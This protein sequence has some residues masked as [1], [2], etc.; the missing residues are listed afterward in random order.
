MTLLRP[1]LRV[2]V[3]L[4][5][6]A[7]SAAWPALRAV[8]GI[9]P[10]RRPVFGHGVEVEPGGGA[11]TV[12]GCYHVSQQNTFTGRLT[13]AMLDDVLG[14]AARLAGVRPERA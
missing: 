2:I 13:V 9:S 10:P 5:G 7:W 14:R 4:G 6:F 1:T 3:A 12:L 11:P 8:Y